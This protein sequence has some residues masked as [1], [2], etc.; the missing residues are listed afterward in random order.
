MRILITG[1]SGFVGSNIA[2]FL[3]KNNKKLSIISLDNLSRDSSKINLQ[4]LKKYKIKNYK[5]NI[6]EK[7]TYQIIGKY[8]LI[9]DCCAEAA[10]EKSRQ[11]SELVFN[12]N[13]KGTFFLLDKALKDKGK[14][15]FLSTSRVYSIN[16]IKKK[17]GNINSKF[18]KFSITEN[19]STDSPIS[20]YG[21]TKLSSEILIKEYAYI[22][23]IKYIINRF[24]VI[25]GPWQFGKQ[26]QG[27]ISL[28]L[29][30]YLKKQKLKYIG[31]EGKGNQIRDV[32]HID[33]VCE[34]IYEQIKKFNKVNNITFNIGGGLKNTISLKTLSKKCEIITGNKISLFQ[35]K[36][37]SIYDIP[38]YASNNAKIYKYYSWRVKKNIKQILIDC[39][40][41]LKKNQLF[42]N[43]IDE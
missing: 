21:F 15:I 14:I 33:D 35:I 18:K 22:K 8:D 9:I 39:F 23:E 13:L 10:V 42:Y 34:L 28:W 40:N 29:W 20:L 1:G 4:R 19:F 32:L 2:V 41:I 26:D 43:K 11:N 37:T 27:F 12:S 25:S 17:V 16:E 38:Y 5:L 36:K 6:E 24:G 30:K 7:R 3:K 31:F